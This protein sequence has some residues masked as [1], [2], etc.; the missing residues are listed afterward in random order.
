LGEHNL[1][2]GLSAIHAAHHV[3]VTFEVACEALSKFC[4]VKRRLEVKFQND[5]ITLYD[6]FAH[7]PSAIQTTLNG[8]R[9][10]VNKERIVVILELRSNTMRRGMHQNSLPESLTEADEILILRPDNADWCVD[11]VFSQSSLYNSIDTIV[12]RLSQIPDGHFVIM[13]NGG[14]G[15]IFK[16]LKQILI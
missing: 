13:S 2:S 11:D 8:L 7:H 14:F 5:L 4:G 6:D 15:G 16:K 1:Q 3:G 12:E 10:K 9:A